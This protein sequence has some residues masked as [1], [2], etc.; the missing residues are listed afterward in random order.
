MAPTETAGNWKSL[1]A[2]VVCFIALLSWSVQVE[3]RP[4][5]E[6]KRSTWKNE[7]GFKYNHDISK[8]DIND[9][10]ISGLEKQRLIHLITKL[11]LTREGQMEIANNLH[12]GHVY[13]DSIQPAKRQRSLFAGDRGGWGGGYG[14]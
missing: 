10:I 14:K 4:A 12:N 6:N 1:V 3:A 7:D 8:G 5:T 13:D 9:D 2:I 11:L